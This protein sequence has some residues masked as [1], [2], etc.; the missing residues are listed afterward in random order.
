[1]L[2]F[3]QFQTVQIP[4]VKH[5]ADRGGRKR[6]RF[7]VGRLF[8]E[9]DLNDVA[10]EVQAGGERD[11]GAA[12]AVTAH[13]AADLDQPDLSGVVDLQ[14]GMRCAVRQFQTVQRVRNDLLHLL[15]HF[16]RERRTCAVSI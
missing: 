9:R 8:A 12:D 4:L 6:A 1:M 7:N 5:K 3:Q 14:L 10:D 16:G 15:K 2:L 13:A 11:E